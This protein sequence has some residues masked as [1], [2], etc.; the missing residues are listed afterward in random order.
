[1]SSTFRVG[2]VGCG[3]ISKAYLEGTRKFPVLELAGVADLDLS[4]AEAKAAEFSTKAYSV[5]NLLAEKGVDLIVNLTVPKVHAT[6]NQAILEAGKHAYVE[7]PFALQ[8]ADGRA[9]IDL[10]KAKGL[11]VGCAPDTF[12][13]GGIQT[14]RKLLDDGAIGEPLGAVANMAGR[15]PE[16]WHPD[17]EFFYQIGGGPMLDMGP[18]YITDLVNLLGPVESVVGVATRSRDERV[19]AS[20]ARNGERFPVEVATHVTG[21]LRFVGGAAVSMTMSFDVAKHGH[22]PIEIYGE[23]GALIVP[24]PNYFGGKVKMAATGKSWR[25]VPVKRPYADDNYRSLGLADMAQAIRTGRPHRASGELALHALEVMQAFQRSSDEGRA[26]VIA[27]RP[28]RPAA[29][30]S[31]LKKGEID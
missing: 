5:E 7:K 6:V 3:N 12:L 27:S 1:M 18:Y 13:G 16:G 26:I 8:V 19:A 31:D 28:A 9:V 17:P 2:I 14:A 10:A 4:R 25:G 21:V 23:T 30:P 22:A 20:A 11:R 24:D 29:L 15:G